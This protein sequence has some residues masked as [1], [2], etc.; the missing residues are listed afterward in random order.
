MKPETAAERAAVL[1]AA[2]RAFNLQFGAVTLCDV[3]D[4]GETE[5]SAAGFTRAERS[6]R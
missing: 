4:D 1:L 6:T 5:A 3:F 2:D